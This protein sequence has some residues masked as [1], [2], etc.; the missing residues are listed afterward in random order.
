MLP[1]ILVI[2]LLFYQQ[3]GSSVWA[4]VK[5]KPQTG[6][7]YKTK[8]YEGPIKVVDMRK[9]QAPE[10]MVATAFLGIVNQDTA[11][12]YLFLADHHVRQLEDTE[13]PYEVIPHF[14]DK[15]PGLNSMF[16]A[17][18]SRIKNIYIWTPDEEWTWNMALMLSAQNKGLPFGGDV[19]VVDFGNL[20]E[21]K[22]RKVE[23]TMGFCSRGLYL[24][25]GKYL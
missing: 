13:R 11:Q 5:S 6:Q 7:F 20:V 2:V 17:Y 16:R 9:D 10:R 21:G 8:M 22:C 23:R 1:A 25:N 15:N 4:S 12:C 18:D 14:T 24:G 3:Y 19:S